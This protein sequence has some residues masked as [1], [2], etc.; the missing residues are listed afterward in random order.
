[1]FSDYVPKFKA[2]ALNNSYSFEVSVT[3]RQFDAF[4]VE[5]QRNLSTEWEKTGLFTHSPAV[6]AVE[7]ANPG[8]PEL[9][10]VRVRMAK[11]NDPVGQYSDMQIVTLIP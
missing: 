5:F 1:M 9:I 3:K 4:F 11:G 8:L 7:P 2:S 10:R 6:I